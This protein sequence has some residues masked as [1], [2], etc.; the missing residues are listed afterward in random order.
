MKNDFQTPE[1][2]LVQLSADVMSTS[3]GDTELPILP[4]NGLSGYELPPV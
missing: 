3:L 1:L 2:L 4:I